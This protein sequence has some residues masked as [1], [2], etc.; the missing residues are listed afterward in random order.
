VLKNEH[1]VFNEYLQIY[2][3]GCVIYTRIN[4][5]VIERVNISEFPEEEA[6]TI[7]EDFISQHGGLGDFQLESVFPIG[8]YVNATPVS[9]DGYHINYRHSYKDI[10][11]SSGG[12]GGWDKNHY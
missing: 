9:I 4:D 3:S 7:A 5:Y 8:V 10:P 2:E 11:I 1:P 6:L 12:G